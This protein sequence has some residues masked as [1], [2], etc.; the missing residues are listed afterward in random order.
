MQSDKNKKTM[1]QCYEAIFNAAPDIVD[2]LIG[3]AKSG[4]CPHAK[5]LFDLVE[6]IPAREKKEKDDDLPGPSLAEMLLERLQLVEGQD[7]DP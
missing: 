4:S 6:A 2:A 3:Q 5:F 1:A 7:A